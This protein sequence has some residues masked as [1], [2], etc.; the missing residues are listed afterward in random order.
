M[1]ESINLDELDKDDLCN[2]FDLDENECSN[3]ELINIKYDLL[4][5]NNSN[6][7]EIQHLLTKAKNKLIELIEDEQEE[8]AETNLSENEEK[9]IQTSTN[10]YPVTIKK[11]ILNPNYKNSTF[12][13]ISIDSQ[14]RNT[15]FPYDASDANSTSSNTH[16][17]MNLT[18]PLNNVISMKLYS[19]QIPYSWYVFDSNLGNNFFYIKDSLNVYTKIEIQSGN[20]DIS[21]LIDEV[22]N[23]I[24][25]NNYDSSL[26]VTYSSINGKASFNYNNTTDISLIFYDGNGVYNTNTSFSKGA[27]LNYNLGWHLGFRQNLENNMSYIDVT[28][29]GISCEAV[30]DVIGTKYLFLSVD[31]NNHNHLNRGIVN[32]DFTETRADM[33]STFSYDLNLTNDGANKVIADVSEPRRVSKA[34]LTTINAIQQNKNISRNRLFSPT[35]SD[36]LAIIPINK[37][38]LDFNNL[39][40]ELGS[41]LQ[42]NKRT[43]FGPVHIKRL[44]IKLMNDKGYTVNLNGLD[45]SFSLIT[46]HLYQY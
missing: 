12:R 40:T 2:L 23:Q 1:E 9:Y 18:E 39:I 11:D 5:K 3:V 20:Y 29:P 17:T 33:P 16:F 19:L 13:I 15:L 34:T 6:N 43:Y 28:T 45:W 22:N 14:Y 42:T 30:I 26:N 37:N 21:G 7:N 38:N 24:A 32:I 46:E 25:I 27:Q 35:N 41:T 36:I 31:D 4:L 8:F 10:S 44:K